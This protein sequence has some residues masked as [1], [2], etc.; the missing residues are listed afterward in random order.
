M[1]RWID[2]VDVPSEAVLSSAVV[3]VVVVAVVG[4][5]RLSI[6]VIVRETRAIS[7]CLTL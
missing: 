3:V 5:P 7:D 6:S 2:Y 1:D 4:C